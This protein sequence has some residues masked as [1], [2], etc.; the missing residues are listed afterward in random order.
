MV[1]LL[2]AM[3]WV[4]V[5]PV[6][7]MV[8]AR[9]A[10][11]TVL[12]VMKP[13]NVLLVMPMARV[14][15]VRAPGRGEADDTSSRLVMLMVRVRYVLPRSLVPL[16]TPMVRAPQVSHAPGVAGGANGEGVAGAVTVD[17][18]VGDG[19]GDVGAG[20]GSGSGRGWSLACCWR[21]WPACLLVLAVFVVPGLA[22]LLADPGG[23]GRRW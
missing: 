11:V 12:P 14:L 23:G 1:R 13:V 9:V 4:M 10:M 19:D 21:C 2:E 8:R 17:G 3:H 22:W 15:W 16:V 18:G 20:S 6:R 5:P 7:R